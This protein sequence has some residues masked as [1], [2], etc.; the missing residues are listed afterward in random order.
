VKGLR[1]LLSDRARMHQSLVRDS[2]E[3]T[4]RF[5]SD[6]PADIVVVPAGR[7]GVAV[8]PAQRGN[9]LLVVLGGNADV[10]LDP[11]VDAVWF[12]PPGREEVASTIA[13][14]RALI[15]QGESG[16]RESALQSIV[17][18]LE[19]RRVALCALLEREAGA[20]GAPE[21]PPRVGE[22]T[23]W[24]EIDDPSAFADVVRHEAQ[25]ARREGTRALVF[26]LG[27]EAFVAELRPQDIVLIRADGGGLALRSDASEGLIAR[28]RAEH[29]DRVYVL[30][31][32]DGLA[33]L[34]PRD[35]E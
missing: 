20:A 31:E 2:L 22:N 3:A 25:R 35:G 1:I 14:A 29:D 15:G 16:P 10:T 21:T 28:A 11:S 6:V 34:S 17:L 9:G 5:V 30:P 24:V 23:R 32:E 8:E 19:E 4:D 18:A 7:S 26:P 27:A 12:D 13:G 33:R